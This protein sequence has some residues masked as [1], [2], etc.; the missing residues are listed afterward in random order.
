M[1]F[2]EAFEKTL[3][4]EK[5][6]QS[7]YH[8]NGNW[9]GGRPGAGTLKG[10]KYGISAA[11]Y[12]DEDIKNLTVE[13]AKLLA[14]RD[15]WDKLRC[16]QLPEPV[17]YDMF[18]VGFNAGIGPAAKLLQRTLGI[19]EDGVIGKITIGKANGTTPQLLD[20]RFNG[21]F[22]KYITSLPDRQWEK[23]GRG[24][25]IRVADRLIED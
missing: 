22:I 17:R 24:W 13:R 20:K 5:G 12:P 21:H 2:E 15:Y 6:W 23:F 14:R 18:D 25:A 16:D 11:A 19:T 3:A 1:T 8:D 9:T 4:V 10:T 7:N